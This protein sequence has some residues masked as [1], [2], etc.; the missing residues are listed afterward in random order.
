VNRISSPI[1]APP[2]LRPWHAKICSAAAFNVSTMPREEIV[3]MPSAALSRIARVD[4][5]ERCSSASTR[6]R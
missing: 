3:M 4:D 6:S 1:P 5:S 2:M